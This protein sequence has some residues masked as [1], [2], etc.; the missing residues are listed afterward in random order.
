MKND[1]SY[2]DEEI[3]K[4][5]MD[6]DLEYD[7]NKSKFN[8]IKHSDNKSIKNLSSDKENIGNKIRA[9]ENEKKKV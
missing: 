7:K 4:L 5:H 2:I 1:I 9:N 8:N 6:I 3:N